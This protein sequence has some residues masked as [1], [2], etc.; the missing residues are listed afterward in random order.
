MPEVGD[1]A[2]EFALPDQDGDTVDLSDFDGETVVLYFYPKADTPG[3]TTQACSIRDVYDEFEERGV[4]VLGISTDT[5]ED[6]AAFAEKHDLPFTLLADEDGE[7]ARAYDSFAVKEM[8]GE[9]WEI[10]ERNTFVVGPDGK[11]AA[12][13]EGVSPEG[14]GDEILDELD[15]LAA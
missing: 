6:I 4:T 1:D 11:V 9:E 7:V 3:C 15:A 2:P 13:Y 14:H 8:R 5:V 12:V 10:A